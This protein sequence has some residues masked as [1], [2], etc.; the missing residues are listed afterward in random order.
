MGIENRDL[1]R[2]D[3]ELNKHAFD[4]FN[5]IKARM[6]LNNMN[7][8]HIVANL[9]KEFKEKTVVTLTDE[10][11][12]NLQ[13][14]PQLSE[15]DKAIIQNNSDFVNRKMDLINALELKPELSLIVGLIVAGDLHKAS[16][17]LSSYQGEN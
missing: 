9:P 11:F 13:N 14:A 15:E 3:L 17:L 16:N 1:D 5:A 10:D 8:P 6:K 7:S 4:R 2:P 12:N